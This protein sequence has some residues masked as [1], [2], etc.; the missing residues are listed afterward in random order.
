[1]RT[2][3]RLL[4]A[5]LAAALLIGCGDAVDRNVAATVDGVDIQRDVLEDSVVTYAG[6]TSEM[7]AEERAQVGETQREFLGFFIQDLVYARAL[8]DNDIELTDAD[9]QAALD[10]EI[11]GL[12]G[13]D[14][15]E[16]ELASFGVTIELFETLVRLDTR[17]AALREHV[18][19]D[20]QARGIRHILV[21]TEDEA[22][23][24]L[25]ELDAGADFG[26][27]A[28]ERSI[29]PGSAQAGGEYPPAPPGSWVPEFDDAVWAASIGEVV[30]PVETQHGF[31]VIE[32]LDETALEV[33][34]MNPQQ[35]EQ[36]TAEQVGQLL[37]AAFEAA[38]V[39]VATSLGTWDREA[40]RV[41]PHGDDVGVSPE[42]DEPG[43]DE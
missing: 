37:E 19:G 17:T 1:V 11:E 4:A 9:L 26:E 42:P 12:G 15:Y 7:T 14:Q 6:D 32:V 31:H 28:Q 41:V 8:A 39:T 5:A 34:E 23:E 29:D 25:D 20:Q 21:Q 16:D 24:V 3:P 33:D 13:P 10:R 22:L 27:L 38:D 36:L 2:L 43:F 18:V 35:L 30:G 40:R